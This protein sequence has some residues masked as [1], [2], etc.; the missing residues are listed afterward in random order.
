MRKAISILLS[1]VIILS[2][3]A[4][5]ALAQQSRPLPRNPNDFLILV[6]IEIDSLSDA[7]RVIMRTNRFFEYVDYG[8]EDGSGGIVLDPAEPVYLNLKDQQFTKDGLI[9]DIRLEKGILKQQELPAMLR[10]GFYPADYFVI[11]LREKTR[12]SIAQ[13]ANLLVIDIG[14]NPLPKPQEFIPSFIVKKKEEKSPSTEIASPPSVARNDV[15]KKPKKKQAPEKLEAAL[16]VP[17]ASPDKAL[18][19]EPVKAQA[20]VEKLPEAPGE[21]FKTVRDQAISKAVSMKAARLELPKGKNRFTYNECLQIGTVNFLPIVIA[22]EDIKFSDMKVN[23]ARRGL[24]PTATAKYTTTDGKTLGVEFREK[25]YG[26]Q[27]EQ[28]VYYGGRL[29]L[30]VKQAEVNRQVAQAKFDKSEAD[31]VSKV[32]ETFYNMATAQ[33]NLDDQQQ[34]YAKSKEVLAI[35][36]KKYE[37]E[38]TTKLELLNVESQ[39]NQI[40]YQLSVGAK[41]LEIARVNL[42]QAMGVDPQA[43][44]FVDFSMDYKERNID[45]NKA[46]LLAYQY[47]PELHMNEL[48]TEAAGYEEKIARSKDKL[49]VDFTGFLGESGGAYKTERLKLDED[50]FVG[51]KAS[52]PWLGNTGSYNYTKNETSPKLGQNTR[53]EALGHTF[54]FA[55]LNNLTGYSEKQAALIN[56]LKAENELVEIEKAINL[57]VREAHNNYQKALMQIQNTQEKI[58]FREEELKILQSQAE[59]NEAQLSQVLEAMVKLNDE[60]ALYHQAIASYKTALAN[61]NKAIGLIGYFD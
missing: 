21:A 2:F 26:L 42:L 4:H 61:L 36:A 50:W 12:Y 25:T 3:G 11:T 35:A 23:E 57:E 6:D 58:R 39:C 56:K 27:V 44:V 54:E 29:G 49:K 30:T 34:L 20:L 19:P 14:E 10:E 24:Y 43:E 31:L 60:K 46:F 52:K 37:E 53:T 15:L 38:L 51:V 9:K 22:Q 48:L 59:L 17:K 5:I 32:T 13:R 28:P 18:K 47:R 45:L 55:I 8:L 1:A 33:L 41:D 7:G 40:E 16:P